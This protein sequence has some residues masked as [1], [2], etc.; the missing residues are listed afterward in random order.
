MEIVWIERTA[1][2]PYEGNAKIHDERQIA[3]VAASIERLGWRQPIVV[4]ADRTVVIGHC[5][6]L[7]AE[8][9]GLEHVPCVVADDLTEDEIRELR[10][11]DNKTN[12]SAWDFGKLEI[13]LAE[14]DLDGYDFEFEAPEGRPQEEAL[15]LED[16]D[17]EKDDVL[18][19]HC[20]KCG[21][22]FEVPR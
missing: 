21:F 20:P 7:A 4:D 17:R 2:R 9:L 8:R 13:E 16:E 6:L 15:E 1:L 18:T 3:N 10:V 14:L 12:E 22:I 5:R 11:V 19:C